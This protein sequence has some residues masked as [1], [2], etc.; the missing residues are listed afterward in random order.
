MGT[1]S[2]HYTLQ[3][4]CFDSRPE[5]A[6]QGLP[7]YCEYLPQHLVGMSYSYGSGRTTRGSAARAN[8]N[9]NSNQRP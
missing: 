3:A 4:W 6:P 9:S 7:T 1:S 2:Q 8:V 5:G